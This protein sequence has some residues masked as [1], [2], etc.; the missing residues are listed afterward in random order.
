MRTSLDYTIVADTILA[1]Q[2][3]YVDLLIHA[4]PKSS[5]SLIRLLKSIEEADYFGYRRPHITI[6]LPADIDA[7]T[8]NF[9]ENMVWPPLDWSGATHASQITLRH[10]IPKRSFTAAE[11]SSY[12]VESFYPARPLDSHVLVLS[13]QVELSP[14]YYHYL[15]YSLLEHRYSKA[16]DIEY[17]MGISLELPTNYLNGSAP[18]T[19]PTPKSRSNAPTP[20]LWEAPNC[21]AA[22]YFG[23][24]WMEFHSFLGNRV[25]TMKSSTPEYKKQITD[26]FPAWMEYLLELMRIRGY[27]MFYPNYESTSSSAFATVHSELYQPPE[28]Y[29]KKRI[30]GQKE[31]TPPAVDP[32]DSF[33]ADASTHARTKPHRPEPPLLTSSLLSLLPRDSPPLSTLPH[34]SYDAQILTA[35]DRSSFA[36]DY[37][38]TFRREIGNCVVANGKSADQPAFVERS[39]D[40]LFC[41]LNDPPEK[42]PGQVN[43]NPPSTASQAFT[44]PD[45]NVFDLDAIPADSGAQIQ[46]EF[47]AHLNRQSGQKEAATKKASSGVLASLGDDGTIVP[48]EEYDPKVEEDKEDIIPTD[49]RSKAKSE[50]QNHL[51]RQSEQEEESAGSKAKSLI[52]KPKSETQTAEKPAA[53]KKKDTAV[54]DGKAKKSADAKTDSGVDV[55]HSRNPGW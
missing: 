23:E 31:E 21:N 52:A 36:A 3:T 53:V 5:G 51:V 27:A 48:S 12:L 47:A 30:N 54:S 6:E 34:I 37:A 26:G 46:D 1:W 10:R 29:T 24:R 8:Y 49:K 11:A 50:F 18:F 25:S 17:L 16:S 35:S 39:A 38:A 14:L 4:P 22:L 40:D 9:L 20:F 41:N 42:P 15:V 19:P 43:I 32:T 55:D 45:A 7:S 2:T 13:P 33:G 44:D 28:E